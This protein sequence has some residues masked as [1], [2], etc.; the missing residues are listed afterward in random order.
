[1]YKHPYILPAFSFSFFSALFVCQLVII[2]ITNH[3]ML[4]LCLLGALANLYGLV[5]GIRA[6]VFK[7]SSTDNGSE[8][9]RL[10]I[11]SDLDRE[12]ERR[13]SIEKA[14]KN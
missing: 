13:K 2:E 6:G 3:W 8:N 11:M 10:A 12:V 1:M 5:W 9:E 7:S 14:E 4:S